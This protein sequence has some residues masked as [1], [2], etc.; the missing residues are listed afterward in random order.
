[1]LDTLR[2]PDTPA[3]ASVSWRAWSGRVVGRCAAFGSALGLLVLTL[4]VLVAQPATADVLIP[5]APVSL[6]GALAEVG[7]ADL[8]VAEG[9]AACGPAAPACEIAGL[10]LTTAAVGG[11]VLYQTHDTWLPWVQN[12]WQTGVPT[13]NGDGSLPGS[14]NTL[15]GITVGGPRLSGASPMFSIDFGINTDHDGEIPGVF[16]GAFECG[17]GY[18][19][20]GR[21]DNGIQM[22]TMNGSGNGAVGHWTAFTDAGCFGHD[23]GI[24]WLHYYVSS[25]WHGTSGILSVGNDPAASDGS[26]TPW[27]QSSNTQT[28]SVDCVNALNGA[29]STISSTEVGHVD[30][31]VVPSCEGRLGDAW[32]PAKVTVSVGPDVAHQTRIGSVTAGHNFS[33]TSD[34][35]HDCV[36][37]SGALTCRVA[38]WVNGQKCLAGA[39]GVCANWQSIA[40]DN[41][42]D[43]QCKYGAH[44]VAL[45]DCQALARSYD[46]G[47]GTRT[48][49]GTNPDGS[50]D[51][52]P[53]GV[54]ATAGPG[55]FPGAG[56]NPVAPR[57]IPDASGNPDSQSCYGAAW[58]W[59]PVDW[60]V[61]P[62]KC[63]MIALFIPKTDVSSRM[64]DIKTSITGRAP[65]SWI[66][67]LAGIGTGIPGGSCPNWV[68]HVGSYEKNIVCDSSYIHAIQNARP[69]LL[70]FM[71]T[72]A[73]WPLI[74]SI[75]YGS[76]PIISAKA[77]ER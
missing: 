29:T 17:D 27:D 35:W 32:H 36:S 10:G 23:G 28:T 22:D 70:G 63:A 54:P 19:G 5:P 73:F 66:A 16:L 45:A 67:P 38:V 59:N 46:T 44:V 8:A 51:T 72:L 2:R 25:R 77:G 60:V 15:E 43:V 57:V 31:Y 33:N 55:G 30:R 49:T 52:Q 75:M 26:A 50:V 1:M 4:A 37:G 61:V 41:P 64:T 65:F 40:R 47:T 24:K 71:L 74:R 18:K 42:D 9:A 7:S 6:G 62:M 56:V 53:A 39:G 76:I 14:V 21:D 48:V 34:P 69:V 68:V 3:I 58:G 13:G 20:N 12:L 11:F